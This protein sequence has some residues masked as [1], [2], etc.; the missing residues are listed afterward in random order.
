[1]AT[2]MTPNGSCEDLA[3]NTYIADGSNRIRRVDAVTGIVTT[4]ANGT[5]AYGYSGDGG[6]AISAR[7]SRPSAVIFDPASPGLGHLY[8]SDAGNN[9]VRMIDLNTNII[10]TVVG[11]GVAGNSGDGY[12]ATYAQ[13][14]DPGSLFIDSHRNLFICDRGNNR[15]RKLLINR[16]AIFGVAGTGAAGFSGDGGN[17]MDATFS[18]PMGIWVDNSDRIYIADGGNQRIR[19]ITPGGGYSGPAPTTPKPITFVNTNLGGD[20]VSLFPN[21]SNGI[22]SVQVGVDHADASISVFNIIGR[23]VYTGKLADANGQINLSNQAP[24]IYTAVVKSAAGTR[25]RKITIQ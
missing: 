20:E 5:G 10:T 12:I 15:I 25:T 11:T 21:P 9:V 4:I 6:L 8:I 2:M 16:G 24:G 23:M 3:G 13:L 1:M 7:F 22:F 18:Y 19:M 14:R 17:S